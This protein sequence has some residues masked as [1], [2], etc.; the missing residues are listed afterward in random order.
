V[1]LQEEY[2][3]EME[4]VVVVTCDQSGNVKLHQA[5]NL[6]VAGA[7]GGG[8]RETLIGLLF[9]NP[10]LNLAVGAGAGALSGYFSDIGA[11]DEVMKKLGEDLQPGWGALFVLVRKA[12]PNKVMEKLQ[13]S[14]G[15]VLRTSLSTE[16]ENR[17]REVLEKAKTDAA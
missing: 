15:R 1:R 12:A 3:I 4:D 6:T 2:L 10:P 17:L 9:L 16:G 7:L 13:E 11:N 14:S 8:F 5:Q